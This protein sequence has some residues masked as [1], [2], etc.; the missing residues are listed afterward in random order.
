VSVRLEVVEDP[1]TACAELL[2]VAAAQ[3]GNIVLTGGS[4]PKGAYEQIQSSWSNVA[5]WFS[6]ERCVPPDDELS[7]YGMAKQALLDRVRPAE[8]HRMQGELG[9]DAA[10]EAYEREL[11]D[12]GLPRFDLALLGIGPDGHL[13]SMFPDQESLSERSRLV[14][15]VPEA[16]L[17][18]FVPR[19]TLTFPALA[20]AR[21]IVYL[22]TG[23]SKADAVAAAFGPDAKPDPHV[24]SSLLATF[25]GDITVVLDRAAASRVDAPPGS[26]S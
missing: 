12:A 11:R 20:L 13:C 17:E 24:P 2:E 1:G 21:R 23:A 4:S 15:G 19:V 25:A 14:V 5:V 8:V 22:V 26:G 18:P 6:D 9:P 16:G 7:N 10:A 3:G